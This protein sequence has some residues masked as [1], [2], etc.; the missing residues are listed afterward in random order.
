MNECPCDETSFRLTPKPFIGQTFSSDEEA[1]Q[2]Y[3]R[4]AEQQGFLVRK[5]RSVK[6]DGQFVRRDFYCHRAGKPQSKI[7]DLTRD[8]R[9]R[10]SSKYGCNAHLRITYRKCF[11]VFPEEWHVT[12][13]VTTYTHDL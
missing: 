8:P 10:E 3:K 2:F 13:Y 4:Y 5:D 7:S 12:K 6:K 1:F 11:D 9:N